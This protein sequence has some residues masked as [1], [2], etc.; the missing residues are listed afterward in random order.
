MRAFFEQLGHGQ[1][2]AQGLMFLYA[3]AFMRR[4][5]EL[6]AEL[7]RELRR[8]GVRYGLP[9]YTAFGDAFL[10]TSVATPQSLDT[11][12]QASAFCEMFG[13]K[14]MTINGTHLRLAELTIAAGDPNAARATV[15]EALDWIRASGERFFES[16]ALR[17]RGD[18]ER[19]LGDATS[20]EASYGEAIEVARTQGARLFELRATNGL[21]Q[22]WHK[23]GRHAEAREALRSILAGFA[24]EQDCIDVRQSIERLAEFRRSS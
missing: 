23:T 13:F 16:E 22:L 6:S 3:T 12:V 24:E 4:E 20:A 10:A 5:F 8:T 14:A 18:A 9:M 17:T 1:T 19:A 7:A 21:S 15:V 2:H 11:V